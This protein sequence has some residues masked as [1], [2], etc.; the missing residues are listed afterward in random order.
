MTKIDELIGDIIFISFNKVEKFRDVGISESTGHYKLK[1]FD[2]MGIWL[3]HPG[4]VFTRTEDEN[5][6][7]IPP[8]KQ[9]HEEVAAIFLVQWDNIKT[10]MHYP[11]REGFDFPSEFKKEIGFKFK[12]E[13]S[14]INK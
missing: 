10:M 1:G 3:E 14:V 11:D 5:G 12:D 7:P 6:K 2:Q 4:I 8:D 13:E 9:N